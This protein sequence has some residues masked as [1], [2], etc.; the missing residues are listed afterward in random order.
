MVTV[1]SISTVHGLTGIICVDAVDY[2]SRLDSS[3]TVH[4][5]EREF[6]WSMEV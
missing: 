3:L 6:Y 4:Q 2:T 1:I 5:W